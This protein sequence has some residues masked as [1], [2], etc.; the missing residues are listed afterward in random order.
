M[1]ARL[2]ASTSAMLAVMVAWLFLAPLV[3]CSSVRRD[4]TAQPRADGGVSLQIR[5]SKRWWYPVTAEGPFP[6]QRIYHDIE[7]IGPGEDWSF[8]EQ[9]GFFYASKDISCKTPLWDLGYAWMDRDRKHVSLNLY[10]ASAPD[11]VKA[12]DINGR[13]LTDKRAEPNGAANQSQPVRTGT[14]QPPAAA[15]SGR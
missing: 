7:L 15:G 6:T 5:G 13:Y 2:I 14:N 9:N 3:G 8:R 10:W 4:Y 12:A 11:H 1:R